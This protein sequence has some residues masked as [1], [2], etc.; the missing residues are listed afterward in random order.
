VR[1]R[2]EHGQSN[3]Q[4]YCRAGLR[5]RLLALPAFKRTDP[6]TAVGVLGT[7]A[8]SAMTFAASIAF[9]IWDR[10]HNYIRR[11]DQE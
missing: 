3:G 8:F 7:L 4:L 9:K 1:R 10:K 2:N 5:Q 11:E 6:W